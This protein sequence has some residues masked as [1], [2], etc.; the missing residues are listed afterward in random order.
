MVHQDPE[1]SWES[2]DQQDQLVE[3]E[4]MVLKDPKET[5][6]ISDH[7]VLQGSLEQWCV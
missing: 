5:P 2:L 1:V 3:M 4:C 6:E 7:Q